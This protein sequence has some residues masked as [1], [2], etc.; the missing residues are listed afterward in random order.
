MALLKRFTPWIIPG[1]VG[2]FHAVG[3]FF[4][5]RVRVHF[6]VDLPAE[7]HPRYLHGRC[8]QVCRCY[9]HSR[10]VLGARHWPVL[11]GS[12]VY[13]GGDTQEQWAA[14]GVGAVT[15]GDS[16]QPLSLG[17][18]KVTFS[19]LGFLAL[20]SAMVAIV[21][22]RARAAEAAAWRELTRSVP[23]YPLTPTESELTDGPLSARLTPDRNEVGSIR[24]ANG[25]IWRFAFRSHHLLGGPDSFSVFAGP[26]GTFRVRGTYFCCEVQLPAEAV[27]KDSAEFLTFLRRVHSS[28]ELAQ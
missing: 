19:I 13:E 28:V 27:S 7:S 9:S 1:A 25:D 3:C 10:M 12:Q 2:C 11:R 17:L 6:D 22:H 18:V 8:A 5:L 16:S 21:V 14:S 15:L 20:V 23:A 24:L 26:S 4:S